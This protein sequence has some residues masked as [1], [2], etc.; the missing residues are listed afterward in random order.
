MRVEKDFEEL[1]RLFNKH[2]VKYCIVG[3]FAV[4]FYGYPRYTKDI[5]I[6][7]EPSLTNGLKITKALREFGFSGLDINPEDFSRK[8]AIIQ[9]GYEPVRVDIINLIKGASFKQIWAHKT[10][11][12]YGRQKVF[13]IGLQ[14]LIKSKEMVGRK[15]DF[16]DLELLLKR[17]NKQKR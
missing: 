3:A 13:F 6:L 7:V 16:A 9:L 12:P 5:D 14:E 15:Q 17:L 8:G 2:H 10:T 4:G 11:G 1:L